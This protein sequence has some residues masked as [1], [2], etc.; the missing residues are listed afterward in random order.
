MQTSKYGSSVL[1]TSPRMTS[2]RG[3]AGVPWTRLVISAAIRGSNSTAK[4][5]FAFSRIL[6]VRFPVP[7]PISSTTYEAWIDQHNIHTRAFVYHHYETHV[8]LLQLSLVHNSLSDTR[9]LQHVLTDIRIH[10]KDAVGRLR[11]GC[12]I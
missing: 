9:V 5:F 12:G 6:T 10:L 4:T 7:G 1:I 2:R 8:T 3:C 11:F